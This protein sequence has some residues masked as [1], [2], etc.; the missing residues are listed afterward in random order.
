[1]SYEVVY[2][3]RLCEHVTAYI[4]YGSLMAMDF[5]VYGK[6]IDRYRNID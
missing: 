4:T 6:H 3:C 1:M 5:N 2:R